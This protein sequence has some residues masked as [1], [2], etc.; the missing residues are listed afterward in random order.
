[1]VARV[2]KALADMQPPWHKQFASIS[3]DIFKSY[4]LVQPN[5]DLVA[6]QLTKNM[7]SASLRAQPGSQSSSRHRRRR[8]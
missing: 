4:S 1:M 5:L 6:T 8:G 7:D 2:I 3:S